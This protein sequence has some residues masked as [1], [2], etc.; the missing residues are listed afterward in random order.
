M[1]ASKLFTKLSSGPEIK[2][3]RLAIGSVIACHVGLVIDRD[4]VKFNPGVTFELS[5]ALAN[6]DPNLGFNAMPEKNRPQGKGSYEAGAL[7]SGRA[8]HNP[9][10]SR[11]SSQSFTNVGIHGGG[12][13]RVRP[14]SEPAL[15]SRDTGDAY[16]GRSQQRHA[17][18]LDEQPAVVA[19]HCPQ[20]PQPPYEPHTVRFSHAG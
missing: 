9:L 13:M 6:A 4:K 2:A 14:V 15:S 7:K 1:Y 19:A 8:A 11:D 12:P 16:S 3:N 18:C 20:R 5:I 10:S 17:E